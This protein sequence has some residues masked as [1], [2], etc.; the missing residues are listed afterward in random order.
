VS[1]RLFVAVVSVLLAG[2]AGLGAAPPSPAAGAAAGD[3]GHRLFDVHCSRCHG[4]GG[5][6]G[7]GPPLTR[8]VLRRA[9]DDATLVD[10]IQ[11][12]IPR[13]PM[14]G[15]F[16]L[17]DAEAGEVAAYVRSLGRAESAA[18]ATGDPARGRAIY[19]ENG[20]AAC[21]I[22][23]GEGRGIGPELTAIGTLRGVEHLRESL[24]DAKAVVAEEFRLVSIRTADGA[25]VRGLRVNE[26]D[27]SLLVRDA[28]GRLH[29]FQIEDLT[30]MRLEMGES[31]MQ[32]YAG[33]LSRDQIENLV[34]YLASLRGEKE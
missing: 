18:P 10:I 14:T 1:I 3:R 15:S 33:R 9:P 19:D 2:F 29:S 16:A 4:I 32:S 11:N 22:V 6:G 12:G 28:D 21:H 7:E 17:S 34:A 23:A 31:L 8:P 20:C 24:L 30:S 25:P 27:F 26:D 5:G 13:T